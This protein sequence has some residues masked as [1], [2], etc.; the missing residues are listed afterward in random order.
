[1]YTYAMILDPRFKKVVSS[2]ALLASKAAGGVGKLIVVRCTGCVQAS[3]CRTNLPHCVSFSLAELV[4]KKIREKQNAELVETVPVPAPV[5]TDQDNF[6][7]NIDEAVRCATTHSAAAEL[8]TSTGWP[9][10]FKSYLHAPPVDRK[11]NPNPLQIWEN[12]KTTYPHVYEVAMEFIPL[13]SSSIPCEKLFSHAGLIGNQLRNRLS[14]KHL[15]ML[16]FL[17]SVPEELWF[18]N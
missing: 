3:S 2:S 10:E 1:M 11:S 14:G 6:W 12:L 5:T 13:L 4:R 15:N 18:A 16:N 8:S 7:G 17:R 9:E